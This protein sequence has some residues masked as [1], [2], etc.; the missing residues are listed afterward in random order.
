MRSDFT[1]KPMTPQEPKDGQPVTADIAH[2]KNHSRGL[3]WSQSPAQASPYDRRRERAE[4]KA[5]AMAPIPY[6]GSPLT[7]A[8]NRSV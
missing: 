1:T 7:V 3:S 8:L 6:V 5:A 4:R 2:E